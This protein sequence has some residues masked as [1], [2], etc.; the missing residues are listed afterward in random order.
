MPYCTPLFRP[1]SDI[2]CRATSAIPG[3]RLVKVSGTPAADGLIR[4]ELH[5]GGSAPALGV[6]GYSVAA[7]DVVAV[8]RGGVLPIESASSINAAARVQ[9]AAGGRV[10][11]YSG[12]GGLVV[13]CSVD[14]VSA[15]GQ[16][17][18]IAIWGH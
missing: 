11:T 3:G 9:A 8:L 2:T 12:T 10:E 4:V 1:G 7:G 5:N 6:A 15:A 13:G 17:T 14:T 16:E 18:M